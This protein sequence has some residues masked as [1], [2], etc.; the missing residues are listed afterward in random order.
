MSVTSFQLFGSVFIGL[1]GWWFCQ[2]NNN[3]D[4][5]GGLQDA[6]DKFGDDTTLETLRLHALSVNRN[7]VVCNDDDSISDI[8]EFSQSQESSVDSESGSEDAERRAE[9][10]GVRNS[11]DLVAPSDIAGKRCFRHRKSKKL[12]FIDKTMH[13]VQYFKMWQKMQ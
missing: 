9:L 7:A 1:F 8:S 5:G 11:V 12:H 10:D 4:H 3:P 2:G 6:L 13:G